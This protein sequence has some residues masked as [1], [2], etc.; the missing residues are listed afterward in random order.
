MSSVERPGPAPA[1]DA[2]RVDEIGLRHAVEAEVDGDAARLV[3]GDA[4][5]GVAVLARGSRR[6]P[7]A[8]PCR[9]CR[10]AGRPALLQR[11]QRRASSTQGMHQEAKKLTSTGRCAAAAS[12]RRWRS[13][14]AGAW[15]GRAKSGSLL[16]DQ[17]ARARRAGRACRSPCA[18]AASQNAAAGERPRRRAGSV[19]SSAAAVDASGRHGVRGAPGRARRRAAG[20]RPATGAADRHHQRAEPD[21]GRERVDVQAQHRAAVA[22][23]AEH[24]IEVA[25]AR[26]SRWRCRCVVCC[27]AGKVRRDGCSVAS[28]WPLRAP[29]SVATRAV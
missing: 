20:G 3:A 1:H 19:S 5:I 4:G 7:A 6:R 27:C 14:L 12:T 8:C 23:L 11:H 29:A 16:A 21:P 9:R 10:R 15:P 28:G 13:P 18:A 17:R 25:E 26:W 2:L 22:L 24:G